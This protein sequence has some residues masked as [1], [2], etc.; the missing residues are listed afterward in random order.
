MAHAIG[1]P[2]EQLE[3]GTWVGMTPLGLQ[4]VIG[5]SVFGAVREHP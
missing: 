2:S 5:Q 4:R 1:M 3:D